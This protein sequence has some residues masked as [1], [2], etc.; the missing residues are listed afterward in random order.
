MSP[1][2]GVRIKRGTPGIA[3]RQT[4]RSLGTGLHEPLFH[5]LPA[6]GGR[7]GGGRGRWGHSE[8]VLSGESQEYRVGRV[9]WMWEEDERGS[10]EK[11]VGG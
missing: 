8:Q 4:E 2:L 5:T 3:V 10:V 6:P 1:G 11:G 9:F 7:W